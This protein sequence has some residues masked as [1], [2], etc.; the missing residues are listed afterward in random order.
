MLVRVWPSKVDDETTKDAVL[1][2]Q[3][4]DSDANVPMLCLRSKDGSLYQGYK[5]DGILD[6]RATQSE[7]T[8][9]RPRARLTPSS[10]RAS[11]M[12]LFETKLPWNQGLRDIYA[13]RDSWGIIPSV[14]ASYYYSL[15]IL[16]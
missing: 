8:A 12:R 4:K 5:F 10:E 2:I 14:T 1:K 9:P 7:L 6:G 15:E 16:F 11:T 13:Q 3:H